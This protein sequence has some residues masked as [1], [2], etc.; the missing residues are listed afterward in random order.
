[1]GT[2]MLAEQDSIIRDFMEQLR[3][4]TEEGWYRT[5]PAHYGA[6]IAALETALRERHALAT[7]PSTSVEP[8]QV[9]WERRVAEFASRLTFGWTRRP[10]LSPIVV[11]RGR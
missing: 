10:T 5:K 11:S 4:A 6:L 3:S 8:E 1:M 9:P 2:W 7:E